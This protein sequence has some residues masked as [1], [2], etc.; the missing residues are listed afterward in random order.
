MA[1]L[2]FTPLFHDSSFIGRL[3]SFSFRLS[4]ILIGIFAMF[5]GSLFILALC[6]GWFLLP[7]L[8]IV[9]E[10]SQALIARAFIFSGI[11]IFVHHIVSHPHKK[12]WNIKSPSDI[13]QASFIKKQDLN[14]NL[15]LKDS[16]VIYL[17]EL[18]EIRPEQLADITVSSSKDEILE[19]TWSLGKKIGVSYL[20]AEH[21]FVAL[22]SL[23]PGVENKLLKLGVDLSD[24]STAL[25]FMK[26]RADLWRMVFIFDEDFHTRHLRGVN[27]GW[28]GVPTPALD[29]V[30]EDLTKKA[31]K[32]WIPDFVGRQEEVSRV[33][34]ILSLEA[35]RNV[36]LVGEPGSGR[37]ALVS[38]LAKLII[39]GDAPA[40]LATKRVVRLDETKLLAGVT[41]QG[42]LA[43]RIKNIFDEIRLSGNIIVYMDEIQNF[44]I[45]EAGT[46]Y[47][48]YS[49]MLS[50]LESS[51]FQFVAVTDPGSYTRIL[52]KDKSFARIFTKIELPPASVVET[53][54]ILK[55]QAVESE[56]YKKIKVSIPALKSMAE[57]SSEFIHDLVLPDAAIKVFDE[58]LVSPEN[59]WVTKAVV[60]KVIQA[61]SGVPVGDAG[62][63]LK[64]ELLNLEETIHQR[65]VDQVEAVKAVS[66]VLRRAGAK[67]RDKTRPIGSFL[68]VGPTGVGKTELA[69]TL[70]DVYFKGK[71]SFAR[72]DMSEY[73][74]GDS[75]NRLIGK[76]GEEGE[77]TESIRQHPYS[78]ILLDE[79]EKADPKILTLFLQV[80]DDGR[81][82]SG[83]G[84]T[85]DFTDTIIIATSNAA[86]LNIAQGIASGE[87]MD[88][89][90]GEVSGEL[91]K[92]FRPELI[93]RFDDVVIFKPLSR[94]DLQKIVSFKLKELQE[95]LKEQGFLVDFDGGVLEKLA[96]RGFDPVLGARPLRRLIQDT[97]EA[98]LSTMILEDKLPKGER[99]LATE[100]LLV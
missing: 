24:F 50:F 7:V 69:K 14:I 99:F 75:I 8:A 77:L 72:F 51:D 20:S 55:N 42:E 21:F 76:T 68:F 70:A 97:L 23:V 15:L 91:L 84:K 63:E 38:Y 49:L 6:L 18:L 5:S 17:L 3:L 53:I 60:E 81:L 88:V 4:R 58:S 47:N 92:I 44:G 86:S 9:L 66:D 39:S 28:L 78:I 54:D 71:G 40:S 73:Q 12:I 89:L 100:Q 80:L 37:G 98:R 96:E 48:L 35:G 46:K 11:V 64:G 2:L 83:S 32:G 22:L 31:A 43:E 13:F 79:F 19:K 82:T 67:L 87:S 94:P 56:R 59:G 34:N 27:R 62:K 30:S 74:T 10:G 93:N 36:L 33:I 25:E 95:R 57:L 61:R 90:K 16:R 1:R 41:N 65:M 52:E 29:S 26:R 45:G 85:V